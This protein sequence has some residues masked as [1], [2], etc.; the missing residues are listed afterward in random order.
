MNSQLSY[1]RNSENAS[2]SP[3]TFNVYL[4]WADR[5]PA[6]TV[7]TSAVTSPILLM[8]LLFITI[9]LVSSVSSVPPLLPA[10]SYRLTPPH[11]GLPGE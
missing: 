8:P 11:F 4:S 9:S 10:R 1:P 5:P 3:G 7:L 6:P 2:P